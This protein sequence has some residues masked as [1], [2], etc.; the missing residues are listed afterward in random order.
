MVV[1]NIAFICTP[2]YAGTLQLKAIKRLKKVTQI[3]IETKKN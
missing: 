3:F 2:S 1:T